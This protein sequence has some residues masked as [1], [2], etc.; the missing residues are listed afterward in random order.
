M[1]LIALLGWAGLAIWLLRGR[2]IRVGVPFLPL[3]QSELP[4]KRP[5]SQWELPPMALAAVLAAG[6]LAIM[7]AAE[8]MLWWPWGS[9]VNVI[10]IVDRGLQMSLTDRLGKPRF[11]AAA[12]IAD[13][14]IHDE[15]PRA[16]IDLRFTPPGP[17]QGVGADWLDRVKS[18]SPTAVASDDHLEYSIRSALASSPGLVVVVSDRSLPIEDPRLVW[19]PPETK[20][21]N[22]GIESIGLNAKTNP[23]AMIRVANESSQQSADLLVRAGGQETKLLIQL[24][25]RGQRQ[26]YFV[27]LPAGGEIVEAE[28]ASSSAAEINHRAW[29]VRQGGWPHIQT[30]GTISA[31]LQKMI[32][33]Y[34]RHRP[35]GSESNDV[36]VSTQMLSPEISGVIVPDAQAEDDNLDLTDG[37]QVEAAPL[38]T[39]GVDWATVLRDGTDSDAIQM[40]PGENWKPIVSVGRDVVVAV[41]TEP[42]RQVW[43]GLHSPTFSSRADFVVFWSE[44]FDWLGNS[45]PTY[46][47]QSPQM[48]DES[49]K[50]LQ[51]KRISISSQDN[52]LFPGLYQRDDGSLCA[53]SAPPLGSQ[54]AET[55]W[56]NKMKSLPAE[57]GDPSLNLSSGLL[58]AA[59]GLMYV[60]AKY[61]PATKI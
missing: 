13:R 51:P 23:Q 18:V 42:A 25:P 11:L 41:R 1:W 15:F 33:V 45:G 19:I 49:W 60:A 9:K 50:L 31:P 3:W 21:E 28:I 39:D 17:G 44:V 36:V 14:A 34:S 35:A 27:D 26:N 48:L 59:L 10:V 47:S 40:N 8:P 56:R 4:R 29:A 12:E 38:A 52:G 2:W 32:D 46:V 5:Q 55:D 22:V 16:S 61:W 43:F 58:L 6:L 7:A 24:P 57:A 20:I 54:A 37:P 53:I 30:R